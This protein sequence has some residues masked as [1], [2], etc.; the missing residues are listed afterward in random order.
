MK[1][2]DFVYYFRRHNEG[3]WRGRIESIKGNVA[4]VF[5]LADNW[6]VRFVAHIGGHQVVRC[7]A[8]RLQLI[9]AESVL[10][11]CKSYDEQIPGLRAELQKKHRAERRK[12]KKAA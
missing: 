10:D 6:G 4:R 11:N 2:G 1:K 8:G 3:A 7:H 9:G 5:L 12:A